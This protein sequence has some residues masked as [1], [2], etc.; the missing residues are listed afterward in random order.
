MVPAP[1]E[2]KHKTMRRTNTLIAALCVGAAALT[3]CGGMGTSTG[4]TAGTGASTTGALL[5]ALLG[6][7]S[8]A[9]TSTA[10]NAGTLISGIIGQLTDNTSAAS[11][12]GTWDY[13]EPSVQFESNDFLAQAGGTVASSA[14]VKKMDTQYR[15]LG[16]TPGKFSITFSENGTCTYEM[17]DKTYTGSYT[18]NS[19][20]HKITIHGELLQLGSAYATISSGNLALTF[21]S[22][23]LLNVAQSLA[24]SSQ[25]TTLTTLS[26]LSSSFS[27]MKTGFLF[28]RRATK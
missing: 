20:T 9:T 8:S 1:D 11:I 10:I 19:S 22:T 25:N 15:K 21:D 27:G 23:K 4:S 26:S 16:I 28:T 14:L 24:K 17:G 18:Y 3:A 12:V 5:G 7:G 13:K 2:Q 6:G